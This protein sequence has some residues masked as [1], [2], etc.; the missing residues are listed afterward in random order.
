MTLSHTGTRI[1]S[2]LVLL[3]AVP[4]IHGGIP[5]LLS[6]WGPRW[7][8]TSSGSPGIV[9]FS[10]LL[11]VASALALLAWILTTTLRQLPFMPP[12]IA[13]GLRPPKLVQTGPYA[14]SRHPIYIAE[15]LLWLGLAIY[16]GSPLLLAVIAAGAVIGVRF[17]IPREESAL[18]SYFGD[19]YRQYR[20]RVPALIKFNL[21]TFLVL[22]SS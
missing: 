15:F 9:N 11:L 3:F 17:I 5:T 16:F 8:W 10:G 4:L 21:L 13:L 14:W 22:L 19:E 18:E 1:V 12:R 6:R 20:T 2:I 7:G